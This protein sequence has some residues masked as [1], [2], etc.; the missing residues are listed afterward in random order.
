MTINKSF[1]YLRIREIFCNSSYLYF[2]F[3]SWI[4]SEM[5]E[6]SSSSLWIRQTTCRESDNF[7]IDIRTAVES[8]RDRPD[9]ISPTG[10][11]FSASSMMWLPDVVSRTF[12][13]GRSCCNDPSCLKFGWQTTW[14]DSSEAAAAASAL[15]QL[16]LVNKQW[17][18][19][20]QF[21]DR[22]HLI[23]VLIGLTL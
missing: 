16:A 17:D 3:I 11:W 2:C 8:N 6:A 14:P 23:L 9:Q 5:E 7:W 1:I 19:V 4:K 15:V 22:N 13:P 18:K 12:R 21:L 10:D 20:E